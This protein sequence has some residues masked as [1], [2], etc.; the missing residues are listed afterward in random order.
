MRA[1]SRYCETFTGIGDPRYPLHLFAQVGD[2]MGY[3]DATTHFITLE[4]VEL[5]R[6]RGVIQLAEQIRHVI[7]LNGCTLPLTAYLRWPGS[8]LDLR[9]TTPSGRVLM[10]E[11]DIVADFYAGRTEEYYVID[12]EEEGDWIVEV[13]G[14]EVDD[15]GE[16]Y[17]LTVTA[18][19]SASLPPW[20][21]I[22]TPDP[23]TVIP[24]PGTLILVGLGLI[25]LLGLA[26]K[27][28]TRR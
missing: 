2:T 22:P 5:A 28:L 14:V 10:P 25:G 7:P 6:K 13:I 3:I 23:H 15:G 4:G 11:S 16:P 26:R 17:E 12:S 18:G 27:R 1:T 9:I 20:P 8:D 21:D 24:E 19:S